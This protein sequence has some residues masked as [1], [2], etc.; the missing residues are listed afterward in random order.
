MGTQLDAP[1]D[2]PSVVELASGIDALYLSGRASLSPAC[3]DRLEAARRVAEEDEAAS[4][5]VLG[6]EVFSIARHGWGKYRYCLRHA[7]GQVGVTASRRLPAVRIQPRAEFLHGVGAAAVVRWFEGVLVELVGPLLLSVARVDLFADVQGWSLSGDDRRR[8]VGR[9]RDLSTY[10]HGGD[11]TG[12]VFGRRSSKTITARIYDKTRDAKAKGADYWPEVWGAAYDPEEAVLRV[13][14]EVGREALREY[15]LHGPDEVLPA[16]GG[17]WV[18]LTSEWLTY[19]SPTSDATSSRWPVAPEWQ[20]VQRARLASSPI[21]LER[22]FA[23]KRS[24]ELRK[25]LPGL[26]GYVVGAAA[27][28]GLDGIEEACRALP[29]LLRRYEKESR[30]SFRARVAER[31]RELV[32]S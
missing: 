17:L 8:F 12:F 7:N 23:G 25:L 26:T 5:L 11:F 20:A 18:S 1:A 9:C 21:G 2:R 28:L 30:R 3:L 27:L 6:G 32:L 16:V 10:E 29:V 19:R 22:T 13:E 24:G 14:F 4:S 15:D 31:R